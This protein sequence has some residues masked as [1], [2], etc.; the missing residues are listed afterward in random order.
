[1]HLVSVIIPTFNYGTYLSESV[2]SVIDQSGLDSELEVLV[3][4]DGSTDNTLQELA[5]ITDPRVRVVTQ[6]NAGIGAA[7]NTGVANARGDVLAF[8]DADD[9]WREDKLSRAL[10]YLNG[11]GAGK[12]HFSMLQEFLDPGV[13]A[14][15]Q[16]Q[17]TPRLL[18]GFSASCTT[19]HRSDF[20]AVGGFDQSLESCEF[21]QWYIRAQ[22]AGLGSE[23]DSEILTFRRIHSLNRDRAGRSS[24]NQYARILMNKIRSQTVKNEH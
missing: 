12:I 9:Y 14:S 15:E 19:L 6:I 2:G 1:M 8:L 13:L 18:K 11:S 16:V 22:E 4:N 17:P 7:R 20:D 5:T 24:S 21:I 3:V 23:V 10:K